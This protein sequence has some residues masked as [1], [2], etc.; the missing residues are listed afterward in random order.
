[1]VGTRQSMDVSVEH[2]DDRA[3]TLIAEAPGRTV[4]GDGFDRRGG[5]PDRG[6]ARCRRHRCDARSLGNAGP[7]GPTVSLRAVQAELVIF[8]CDGV[9]VD[10]EVLAVRVESALLTEA[11]FALSPEEISDSYVGLSYASMMAS[12][13]ERFGRPVPAELG[14]LVQQRVIDAFPAELEPVAGMPAFLDT[15]EA[16]RCVA[17]SSDLDRVRLSL[18]LTGLLGAFAEDRLFSAQMVD[19]GKPEPDLFLHAA[20]TCAVSPHRCVVVEDSPH[21]VEAGVAAGMR[22][23]GLVAGAH[24]PPSLP[25]RLLAA[26][27]A[28]VAPTVD[29][30]HDYL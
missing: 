5:A 6:A 30:L 4:G 10:S 23:I 7:G 24:C 11:G 9:L 16:P 13:A 22:V 20:Q 18:D 1:M 2:H 19:R 8:D 12:I 17:S 28:A 21:G 14:E 3:A 15:L 29:V 25:D 26:G 27:A